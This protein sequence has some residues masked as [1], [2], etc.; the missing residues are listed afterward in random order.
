MGFAY[1]PSG[2]VNQINTSFPIQYYYDYWGVLIT[3]F[4]PTANAP[5]PNPPT[6]LVATV[7]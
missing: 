3:T 7:Q 2:P 5:T 4:T 1:I 6:K